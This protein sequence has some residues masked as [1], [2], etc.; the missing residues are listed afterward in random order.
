MME[1]DK[2]IDMQ[3]MELDRLREELQIQEEENRLLME[4]KPMTH[5]RQVEGEGDE[6]EEM[7]GEG[8]GDQDLDE[9]P[10]IEGGAL[11]EDTQEVL[12]G[13]YIYIYIYIY[14]S[15][16]EGDSKFERGSN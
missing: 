13:I 11:M 5:L 3:H 10:Q 14:Y 15:G 8:M 4:A 9:S 2:E 7:E 6:G 12:Q 1:K 16:G